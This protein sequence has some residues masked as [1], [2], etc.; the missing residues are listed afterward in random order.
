MSNKSTI[1]PK[2]CGLDDKWVVQ[3]V[4]L[5]YWFCG[6]CRQEVTE[7][8]YEVINNAS[9]FFRVG[10]ELPNLEPPPW[11]RLTSQSDYLRQIQGQWLDDDL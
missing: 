10:I 9:D 3:S 8:A 4:S 2:C 5:Q 11:Y 6:E 1:T 7:R